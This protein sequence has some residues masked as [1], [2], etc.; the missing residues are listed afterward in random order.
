MRPEAY[1]NHLYTYRPAGL[2]CRANTWCKAVA[3]WLRRNDDHVGIGCRVDK[4][5]SHGFRNG[6]STCT[7]VASLWTSKR[8]VC[9]P[10]RRKT[11]GVSRTNLSLGNYNS[12]PESYDQALDITHR[13]RDKSDCLGEKNS[14]VLVNP[15]PDS[16]EHAVSSEAMSRSSLAVRPHAYKN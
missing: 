15:S 6:R 7:H 12:L 4:E 1:N 9:N 8:A 14:R 5:I 16:F 3:C 13:R 10:S 11:Q 2:R